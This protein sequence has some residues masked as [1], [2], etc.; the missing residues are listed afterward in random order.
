MKSDSWTE[1]GWSPS[2]PRRHWVEQTD[3]ITEFTA[4]AR[5]NQG[6]PRNFTADWRQNELYQGLVPAI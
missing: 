4:M 5:Q 1:E 2:A 6:G 3:R